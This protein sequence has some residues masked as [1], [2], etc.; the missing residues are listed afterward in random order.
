MSEEHVTLFHLLSG[1]FKNDTASWG[2]ERRGPRDRSKAEPWGVA[3]GCL[4][5]LGLVTGE[6][7]NM[8][9]CLNNIDFDSGQ[10]LEKIMSFLLDR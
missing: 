6:I 10:M 7:E 8:E 2:M 5:S 4:S 3:K 1:I 9:R